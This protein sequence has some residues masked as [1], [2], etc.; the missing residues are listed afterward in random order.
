VATEKSTER[1]IF[2]FWR[3]GEQWLEIS[4]YHAGDIQSEEPVLIKEGATVVGN[5]FA[6][7]AVV[8]GLLNGSL[9]AR[10]TAVSANGQIWGDIYTLSLDM[11]PGSKVQGWITT[12][13]EDSYPK[14]HK[15]G[16]IPEDSAVFLPTTDHDGSLEVGSRPS[17]TSQIYALRYLQ[18]EA[19]TAMAAR[20]E[21]E[22]AFEKRLM[23]VAGESSA[24]IHSLHEDLDAARAELNEMRLQLGEAQEGVRS[25]ENRL[26]RQANELSTTRVLLTERNR[27][28]N[29]Q[30]K[31]AADQEK[32]NTALQAAKTRLEQTV[33]AA[34]EQLEK[35]NGR[36]H[37][38]ETAFQANLQHSAEQEESLL[39]WQE[40]AEVT[41]K[42]VAELEGELDG[43]RLQVVQSNQINEMLRE[44]RHQ[45][46]EEWQN[47]LDELETLKEQTAV[48][49]PPPSP[50]DSTQLLWHKT[51][52]RA[53]QQELEQTRH[54]AY[55][56]EKEL[57]ELQTV[58]LANQS[59]TEA[60]RDQL[61]A[62]LERQKKQWEQQLQ[63]V[64]ERN[65]VEKQ[66]L[67][68]SIHDMEARLSQSERQLDTYYDQVRN[69][70]HQLAE[71]R[72]TLV[73]KDIA[74]DALQQKITQQSQAQELL[75]QRA[76]N[77]IVDL[78]K[79]LKQAQRQVHDLT[80]ILERKI[81]KPSG[82]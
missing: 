82:D 45:L 67:Q 41:Q 15:N 78:Q 26:K 31:T 69:Q 19:A 27:E 44:Q 49:A 62:D 38:L 13:D 81:K 40:L 10:K 9:I 63:Q 77:Y 50:E 37:S 51:N 71:S 75:K 7:Q 72:A 61:E 48:A 20:S 47:A 23:E 30:R 1:S 79:Q 53:L 68:A 24:K 22:Q 60:E 65:D 34:Q 4:G 64:R 43:L 32:L 18:A 54:I 29:E 35:T 21:L 11:A 33:L 59:Q 16:T 52:L 58:L 70:G 5:V 74:L 2:A 56:H 6:P 57:T 25:R 36:L 17:S 55:T 73:E 14:L 12:L 46:E 3:R 28:L 39:R 76:S 80:Q 8:E 66:I 42:R